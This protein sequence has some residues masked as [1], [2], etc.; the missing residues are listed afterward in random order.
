MPTRLPPAPL[1]VP[2]QREIELLAPKMRTAVESL[3]ALRLERFHDGRAANDDDS[4]M[5][6]FETLRTN[7]RQK[8]LYGQGR[9]Y[10]GKI[11]TKAYD[12]AWTWHSYGMAIDIIHPK[13]LWS[14]PSI[15]WETLALDAEYVG[16]YPGRRFKTIPD[17]PHVQWR[18]KGQFL[19]PLSPTAQDRADYRAKRTLLV[20]ERYGVDK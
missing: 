20:W 15:W 1:E 3:I 11:V 8:F 14:A 4:V 9:D 17:S 12:A 2:R 13:K 16:L 5:L 7:K 6:I 19:T 10:F 18:G